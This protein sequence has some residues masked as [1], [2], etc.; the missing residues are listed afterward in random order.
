MRP[1]STC[2]LPGDDFSVVGVPGDAADLAFGV[3]GVETGAG[4]DVPKAD[5]PIGGAAT[6]SQQRVLPRTPRHRFHRRLVAGVE[7]RKVRQAKTE[8]CRGPFRKEEAVGRE[9]GKSW[10]KKKLE[11]EEKEG[12]GG[13]G[14]TRKNQPGRVIRCVLQA[15]IVVLGGSA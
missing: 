4:V 14:K 8:V 2:S 7:R 12:N 3:D 15:E 13:I 6:R 1:F 5:A 11:E 9:G 10:R